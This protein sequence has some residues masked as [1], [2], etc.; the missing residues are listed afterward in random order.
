MTE[1]QANPY[2]SPVETREFD[3]RQV[4]LRPLRGPSLA[5][6]I[7]GIVWG[8]GAVLFAVV[9]VVFVSVILLTRSDVEVGDLFN[10]RES[11]QL[12]A[13]LPSCFI[14]YGAWCMRRGVRYRISMTAA[15]LACI[16]M[17]S[18]TIWIGIPFG[19]WAVIV[20]RRTDVRE[21]FTAPR[22]PGTKY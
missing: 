20:L 7:M 22:I 18:P 5:L 19:I 16:P 12:F 3:A 17:I 11:F 2:A 10:L 1:Q 14:A 13:A 21:A 15:I 9:A 6:L 4:A 8:G